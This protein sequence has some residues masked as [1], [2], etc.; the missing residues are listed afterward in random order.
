MDV[1]FNL[2]IKQIL[3]IPENP[4]E[5]SLFFEIEFASLSFWLILNISISVMRKMIRK[6]KED[7]SDPKGL[8]NQI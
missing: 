4:T 2:P 5:L 8:M 1:V 6:M 7:N 3:R